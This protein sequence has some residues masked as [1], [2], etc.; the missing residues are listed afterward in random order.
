ML[1]AHRIDAKY[2][3]HTSGLT[4]AQAAETRG[5]DI[6]GLYPILRIGTAVLEHRPDFVGRAIAI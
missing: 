2:M 3:L 6:E 1:A 5:L 4:E